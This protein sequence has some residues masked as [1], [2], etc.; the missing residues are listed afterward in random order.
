MRDRRGFALMASLWLVVAIAALSLQISAG[1]R[2]RRLAVA[3]TLEDQR[4]HAAASSGVEHARARL[5][6]L[7][8]GGGGR[9]RTA[10]RDPQWMT[11]PWHALDSTLRSG[12]GNQRYDVRL[13][14]LGGRLHVNR[15]TAADLRRYFVG[16]RI[17]AAQAQTITDGILD[18]LDADDVARTRGAEQAA[19]LR[20]GA[21]E[22]PRDGPISS[23]EE[24][25]AVRGM[26][27]ELFQRISPD[28]TA[29]GT[30]Q[31]NVNSASRSVLLSLP[32]FTEAAA[33]A[34]VREQGNRRRIGSWTELM[35]VIPGQARAPL[36]APAA[37]LHTKIIYETR[38]VGVESVGTVDGSPVRAVT[39]AVLARAGRTVFVTWSATR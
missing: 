23:V 9:G 6:R 1:A 29:L 32:G 16:L 14:D 31:V 34:V 35:A 27:P 38:E 30:G 24:L 3:N 33:D 13:H 36:L 28:F 8:D 25:R 22:L 19:Y 15:A 21:R 20:S 5:A 2:D 7:V 17:D 37:E 10:W 4:A 39:E 11:D 26:T 12:M 18:W